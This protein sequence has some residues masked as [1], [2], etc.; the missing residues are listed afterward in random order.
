MSAE[1]VV[2]CGDIMQKRPGGEELVGGRAACCPYV[3]ALV[4]GSDWGCSD[5]MQKGPSGEER[6]WESCLLRPCQSA[7]ERQ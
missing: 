4:N 5:Q 2:G 3:K 6:V 7:R 1:V